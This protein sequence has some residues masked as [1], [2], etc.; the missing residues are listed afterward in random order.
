M[1]LTI[2]E[3]ADQAGLT[4]ALACEALLKEIIAEQGRARIVLST[5][6]SQFEFLSHFVKREI[7]WDKV[8]MFHLDEYIGLPESHPASFRR[9]LKERFLKFAPVGRAC[10]IDGESKA[11]EVVALLNKEIEQAPVD[12]ALIGIGENAHIAFNDPPADFQLE[13]P[14][15]IVN[16]SETCKRQQVREG[17]FERTG[18]VPEQAITMTVQHIL[19]SR[20]IVSVVP[21][22]AKAKAIADTFRETVDPNVPATI[23]KTHPSWRLYLDK[24]SSASIYQWV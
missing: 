15:T 3:Q 9:Y 18:D 19:K 5:G 2:M 22:Q 23:L 14:Y 17:W 4:A 11:E 21:R 13:S 8:E 1:Q 20:H 16:L 12:L 10:L 24:E 6:A 7:Q